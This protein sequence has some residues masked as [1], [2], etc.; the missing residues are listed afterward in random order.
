MP[1]ELDLSL[2]EILHTGN[3]SSLRRFS[4]LGVRIYVMPTGHLQEKNFDYI[5]G[6]NVA[7]DDPGEVEI[8]QEASDGVF[9]HSY[10]KL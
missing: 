3:V 7:I 10:E 9:E 8:A 5:S 6:V 1:N 2:R 4:A